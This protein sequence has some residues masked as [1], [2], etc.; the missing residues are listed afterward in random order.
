MG[1]MPTCR[2][3]KTLIEKYQK[4]GDL[5]RFVNEVA[6][7]AVCYGWI[8]RAAME[9]FQGHLARLLE[10]RICS[11]YGHMAETSAQCA[12]NLKHYMG[13]YGNI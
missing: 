7:V 1:E 5:V 12:Q 2:K 13:F 4:T 9:S 6:S 11:E 10:A 8:S 3:A